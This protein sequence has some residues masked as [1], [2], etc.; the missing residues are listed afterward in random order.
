ME[1]DYLRYPIG[2][3][4]IPENITQKILKIGFLILNVF[5]KN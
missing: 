3:V 4:E 2:L 5:L 1:I